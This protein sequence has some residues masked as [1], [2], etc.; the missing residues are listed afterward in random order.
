MIENKQSRCFEPAR[1]TRLQDIVST[2]QLIPETEITP[3]NIS[4]EPLPD[5]APIDDPF[6]NELEGAAENDDDEQPQQQAK[7]QA[8]IPTR[9]TRSGRNVS[10][11]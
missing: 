7:N 5:V 3:I 1:A 4:G 9:V 10:L 6:M 8:R 2:E 11:P